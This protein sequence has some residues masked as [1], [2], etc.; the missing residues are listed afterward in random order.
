MAKKVY[1]AKERNDRITVWTGTVEE[2]AANVFGYT[3]ECGNSWN[4]RINTSPKTAKGLV[5]ALEMSVDATQGGCYIRDYYFETTKE[6]AE[7]KGWNICE[8]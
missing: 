7:A 2:L 5:K 3:L 4:H 8:C 1:I 6:T